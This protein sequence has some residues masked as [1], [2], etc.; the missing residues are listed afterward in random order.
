LTRKRNF[1]HFFHIFDWL[2]LALG[3]CAAVGSG[4]RVYGGRSGGVPD[5]QIRGDNSQSWVYPL[6]ADETVRV[7]GPLGITVVQIKGGEARVLSSPCPKQICVL[8]GPIR[9]P[10]ATAACLPNHVLVAI[11]SSHSKNKEG[12]DALAW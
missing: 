7:N 1:L 5:V 10:G 3:I 12:A 8:E 11:K 2:A 4:V 6:S 9:R